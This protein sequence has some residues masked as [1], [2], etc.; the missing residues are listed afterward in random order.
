MKRETFAQMTQDILK[1]MPRKAQSKQWARETTDIDQ[2]PR[3][4]NLA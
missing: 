4:E 3:D 2:S 1:Q